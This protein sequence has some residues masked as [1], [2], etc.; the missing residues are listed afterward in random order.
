MI[1]LYLTG[2]HPTSVHLMGVCLMGVYLIGVHFKDDVKRS[3]PQPT[4]GSTSLHARSPHGA[5]VLMG[6]ASSWLN[7]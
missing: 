7:A 4:R 3:P 5:A 2:V 6:S 1:Y